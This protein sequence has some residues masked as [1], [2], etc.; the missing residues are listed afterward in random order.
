VAY[1]AAQIVEYHFS[2]ETEKAWRELGADT[3]GLPSGLETASRH[4][5]Q[6]LDHQHD[7]PYHTNA[8]GCK[9]QVSGDCLD[10]YDVVWVH[11]PECLALRRWIAVGQTLTG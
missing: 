7:D 10:G 1:K 8:L 11:S 6:W 5:A 9:A 2:P 3:W 4:V